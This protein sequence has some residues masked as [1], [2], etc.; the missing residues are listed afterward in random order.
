MDALLEFCREAHRCYP[1]PA[2]AKFALIVKQFRARII[3]CQRVAR[4]FLRCQRVRTRILFGI[5]NRERTELE[6]MRRKNAVS[7][8]SLQAR[9]CPQQPPVS[10]HVGTPLF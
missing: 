9:L 3:R 4:D 1:K 10:N 6:R 5:Y 8:Y 7:N 2:P